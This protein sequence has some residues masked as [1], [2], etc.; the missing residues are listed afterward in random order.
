VIPLLWL[1]AERK[2]GPWDPKEFLIFWKDKDPGNESFENV[3]RTPT[4]VERKPRVTQFGVPSGSPEYMKAYRN[5]NRDK[6]RG[7]Q[8]KRY[9]RMRDAYKKAQGKLQPEVSPKEEVLAEKLFQIIG[10]P[11][12]TEGP[13]IETSGNRSLQTTSNGDEVDKPKSILE[14]A[15]AVDDGT[16]KGA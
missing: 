14:Q 9:A 4:S 15:A 11:D 2:F 12:V 6:V 8:K 10:T 13:S 3:E 5:A 1:L 16:E 7:Y